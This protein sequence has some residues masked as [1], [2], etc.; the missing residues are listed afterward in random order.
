[1]ENDGIEPLGEDDIRPAPSRAMAFF[2]DG[3]PLVA[4]VRAI[5]FAGDAGR[6]AALPE[7]AEARLTAEISDGLWTNDYATLSAEYYGQSASGVRLIAV[8]HGTGPLTDDAGVFDAY[9]GEGRPLQGS[10]P[11]KEFLALVDGAFGPVDV[12]ELKPLLERRKF[13]FT[14]TL[15]YSQACEDPLTRARLGRHAQAYLARQRQIALDELERRGDWSVK[16]PCVVRLAD[17][18]KKPYLGWN[19]EDGRAAANLLTLS[20]AVDYDHGHYGG[21]QA[22][23]HASRITTLGT[24]AW[25][26]PARF[27][28]VRGAEAFERVLPG[29]EGVLRDLPSLWS[30]LLQSAPPGEELPSLVLI[31]KVGRHWFTQ[32]RRRGIGEDAFAPEYRVRRIS[33][34]GAAIMKVP[35]RDGYVRMPYDRREVRQFAPYGANAYRFT[36]PP[37]AVWNRGKATHMAVPAAFYRI[38]A[39]LSARLPT[40]EAMADDVNLID[41]LTPER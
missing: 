20:S 41:T 26:T 28:G 40:V 30:L 22:V 37:R 17:P 12:V 13:P 11:A 16:D 34:V 25:G 23:R 18:E 29:A 7:I 35:V 2:H 3:N 31:G 33:P 24:Y 38:D 1:M 19:A 36:G 32:R 14:E 5:R 4:L 39:D 10:V 27:V 8:T 6:V 15:T 9:V 21:K